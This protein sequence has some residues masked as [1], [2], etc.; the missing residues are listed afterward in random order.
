MKRVRFV[1]TVH[2]PAMA[3]EPNHPAIAV[4]SFVHL[5]ALLVSGRCVK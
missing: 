5:A 4:A 2:S 3:T 1:P